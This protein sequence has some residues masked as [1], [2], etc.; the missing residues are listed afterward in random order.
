MTICSLYGALGGDL[1]GSVYEGHGR[2]VHS[3]D[4]PLFKNGCR[5]TDDSI[6]TLATADKLLQGNDYV[7]FYRKWGQRYPNSGFSHTFKKWFMAATPQ[8]PYGAYS[9]GSIMRC[10]PIGFACNSVEEVLAEAKRSAAVSHDHPEGIKGAQAGALAV[11]L[12]RTGR[13]K[14]E[15]KREMEQRLGYVF[16]SSIKEL[17]HRNLNTSCEC[18]LPV[19]LQ[20]FFESDSYESAVRNAIYLGGDSDT[21]AAIAGSV[22]LAFYKEMPS[23]IIGAIERHLTNEMR[24]MCREF[25]SHYPLDINILPASDIDLPP[26]RWRGYSWKNSFEDVVSRAGHEDIG[27]ILHNMRAGVFQNTVSIVRSGGYYSENHVCVSL[28]DSMHMMKGTCFYSSELQPYKGESLS[29]PTETEVIND[30]CIIVAKALKDKGFNPAVLN[31][32]SRQNPGGGVLNGAGAQEENLFRR[33]NLFLSMYPFAPYAE[34]YGLEKSTHHYPLDQNFGG[35][36]TPDACVFRGL[37]QDGYPLL[38]EW[39]NL[40]FISV[41]A[42]NRPTLG[43]DGKIIPEQV[44]GIKNKMRTLFRIGLLKGHDS[45]VLGAWGCGAFRNPPAQIARLFHEVMEE[46]EFKNKFRKIVFAIIE[47]HNSKK[48]HN[49]E[50]NLLP[51][52]REFAE[53]SNLKDDIVQDCYHELKP[54]SIK[55]FIP[56]ESDGKV[57]VM[58]EHSGKMVIPAIYE[59]VALMHDDSGRLIDNIINI[60]KDGQWRLYRL[61]EGFIEHPAFKIIGHLHAGVYHASYLGKLHGFI[62]EKGDIALPFVYADC[63]SFS[64]GLCAVKWIGD[65]EWDPNDGWGYID[66]QGKCIIQGQYGDACKF[67]GGYA[68]VKKR[69]ERTRTYTLSKIFAQL[70]KEGDWGIIDIHG[71]KLM[72][73]LHDLSYIHKELYRLRHPVTMRGYG[74]ISGYIAC[75]EKIAIARDFMMVV[76]SNH[77]VIALDD[78]G[79]L[80]EESQDTEMRSKGLLMKTWHNI[81]AVAAGF[82]HGMAITADGTVIST[83]N[84]REFTKTRETE[85]WNHVR[86]LDACEG[87][88]AAITDSGEIRITTEDAGYE[89]PINYKVQIEAIQHAR[90]LAVGW[91]HAAVLLQNGRVQVFGDA[92]CCNAG[93]ISHWSD[94]IDIDVFGCY[95]S[96]IQTVGLT[97][98]GHVLYTDDYDHEPDNWHDIVSVSCGDY[99]IVGLDSHGKVHACGRNDVGQCDVD[100][101]PEMICA[102]G[103]FFRTI[104]IDRDGW[105]WMTPI[106]KT[107]YR[108][109]P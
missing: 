2:R 64:E 5:L 15:I 92:S 42:M 69:D 93:N 99:F 59:D 109:T 33:T 71:N 12:A 100:D 67:H 13:S 44:A 8:P 38:E 102:K 95:F 53:M 49:P 76:D 68:R 47:D 74:N 98:H 66:R 6:L 62:D 75:K 28:T 97:K 85:Q 91:L 41:P 89:S 31:M 63:K 104:A 21:F 29:H 17:R 101:W 46:S 79:H 40:S 18:T 35:V 78:K 72:S 77:H 7:T 81:Q 57:G 61:G 10:S 39:F 25:A 9:N 108:I 50:G 1:I 11:F 60:K 30:D 56:H 83:G 82:D 27:D 54:D 73:C 4:F 43:A 26:C 94:V 88:V 51:F 58:E 86:F 48:S 80:L 106:G 90:Q 55:Y 23:N 105:I 32:A 103:D 16:N 14:E 87:H 37:E 20:A 24:D 65:D 22:A 96:P 19:S 70:R 45:L 84:T 107:N 3:L 36:Y 52:Q 34:E